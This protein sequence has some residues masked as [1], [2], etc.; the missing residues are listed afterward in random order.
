MVSF[1][2]GKEL[3][4]MFFVLSRT[5]DKKKIH[6]DW[7]LIEVVYLVAK[8]LIWSEA[9]FDHVVKETRTYLAW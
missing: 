6:E 9:E 5:W 4:K 7:D 1:E 8:P 2:L 3:R